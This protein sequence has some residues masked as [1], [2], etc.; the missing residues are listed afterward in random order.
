MAALLAAVVTLHQ[1][2]Q[3]DTP[4]AAPTPESP[5]AG[6]I[7]EDDAVLAGARAVSWEEDGVRFVRLNDDVRLRIGHYTIEGKSALIRIDRQDPEIRDIKHLAMVVDQATSRGGAV[8]EAERLLVT[9]STRGSVQLKTDLFQPIDA[10]PPDAFVDAARARIDRYFQALNQPTLSVPQAALLEPQVLARRSA[11]R[12]EVA[13]DRQSDPLLPELDPTRR[14]ADGVARDT[15]RRQVDGETVPESIL[16]TRGTVYYDTAG[17]AFRFASDGAE[18]RPEDALILLGP[19]RLA[20]QDFEDGRTVTLKA[21]RMVVYFDREDGS[22]PL[23][24]QQVGS[25]QITGIYLEDNAVISSG[26]Y[27]VRSPRVFYDLKNNRAI[28][29]DAVLYTWDT[30]KGVPLYARAEVLRQTATDRFEGERALLTTSEFAEPH[31]AIGASRF[32]ASSKQL[33][34]GAKGVG[35]SAEGVTLQGQGVPFFYLPVLAG[36]GRDLPL[37]RLEVESQSNSG[38]QVESRWDAFALFGQTAPEGVRLDSLI[39]YRGDHGLGLGLDLRYNRPEYRGNALGYLLPQDN[40]DDEIGGRPEIDQDGDPRGFFRL[41]H[42]QRLPGGF[43]LSIEGAYVSDETFLEEFYESLAYSGRPFET[44]INLRK[45]E[46][47]WAFTAYAGGN[48]D[49][50]LPQLAPLTSPG[51]TVDRLPELNYLVTG[52][53]LL[54]DRVTYFADYSIS[55]V[56]ADF[57]DDTPA[58]RGFTDAQAQALFG[59]NANTPFRDRFPGFP[60]DYRTRIDTRQEFS[61][62]V[63]IGPMDVT[64]FAVGRATGYDDDFSEFNGGNNDEYRL[65]GQAGLRVGTELHRTYRNV[66]SSLLD[67]DGLR[68]LITPQATVAFGDTTLNSVALPTFDADIED[69]A[70]GGIFR[71]GLTNTLQTKRGGLGRNRTVD[72]VRLQTDAVFRTD[73]SNAV[74]SV[75]LP[76]YFDYRPELTVGGD[77]FYSQLLW[78][79]SDTL[80]V[81]GD[82]THSFE[83]DDIVQWR[84]SAELERSP[85]LTLFLNYGEIDPLDSQLLSYGL[86]YK[87]TS[88][89]RAGVSQTLDLAENESRTIEL[90]LER[91]FSRYRFQVTAS[92]DEIDEEQTIGIVFIPEGLTRTRGSS[93]FDT[94]GTN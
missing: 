26:D 66:G 85:R 64:A 28:L 49:D 83:S 19:A 62:P 1:H 14:R 12:S 11:R 87:L 50:F 33:L 46:D 32:T 78:M 7:L 23:S 9:L 60:T 56:R 13:A 89:Y 91:R 65:Y 74:D 38:I 81:A 20:Y 17:F 45:Q 69:L 63:R 16:P 94:L 72:W 57:G 58:D 82:L 92:F 55:R 31:L 24:P 29:L 88:K 4:A 15:G 43:D 35:F 21:Q 30:E 59:I 68:H 76:R 36:E 53:S 71:V 73:N 51:Y 2:A 42:R 37:R 47:D 61:A 80:G 86:S 5:F 52:R 70:E 41:Q 34:D 40:G 6:P 90:A 10:A 54:D 22:Q 84:V 3:E 48:S 27:T 44:S 25:E 77:H 93:V 39:D 8:A 67:L 75:V 79:V 18:G